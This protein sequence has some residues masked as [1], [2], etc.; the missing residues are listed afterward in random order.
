MLPEAECI[1]CMGEKIKTHDKK[2]YVGLFGLILFVLI[3]Y[4]LACPKMLETA[5]EGNGYDGRTAMIVLGALVW[6]I[7]WWA[8]SV[9]PDWCTALLLQCIWIAAAGL[10]FSMVFGAF[11]KSTVWLLVGTFCLAGAITKTGLL[12]RISLKLMQFF[13]STYRG[14]VSAMLC[15]GTICGPLMP[16]STAKG[17]LGGK[18]AKTSA[19]LMGYEKN[20]QGRS[21]LFVAAWSGFGL[22]APMFLSASFLSYSMIGCLPEE[23][24][25]VSWM[26]W[27]IAMVPWGI[28]V[29]AGMWLTAA[30]LYRPDGEK[31]FS[32][33]HICG[34]YRDLGKMQTPEKLTG[35][36]LA[37]CLVFW[38]LERTTG[39]SAGI[40]SLVGGM[41]CFVLGILKKEELADCVPWGFVLFVGVVLNLGDVLTKTGIS[42]W[43]LQML[44]PVLLTLESKIVLIC[45]VVAVTVLLRFVLASQTAV[46][47]LLVGVLAPIA[48]ELQMNPFIIGLVVYANVAVWVAFYQNPTYLASLQ[49]MEGTIEHQNTVKAGI[50]Y[51]L[52][53]AA[54]CLISVPYW[55]M[56]GYM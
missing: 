31:S 16:S 53:S 56:L 6:A 54:A 27:L 24:G 10:E 55:G 26:Q 38:I 47:T 13:P 20:S 36:I 39:I 44:G 48:M 2:I 18:L 51:I 32:K 37:V 29:F 25:Q 41:L 3:G 4:V 46:I 23:Y 35:L 50:L 9:V 7:V 43:I 14:Q 42:G 5:A 28:I 12:R 40:V 11:A 33:D 49:G 19:D 8:G 21:G 15:V 52:I 34:L 17:L 30:V 22:L 45:V 1:E